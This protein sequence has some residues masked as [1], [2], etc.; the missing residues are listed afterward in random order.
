MWLILSLNSINDD[1]VERLAIIKT[2]NQQPFVSI[3]FVAKLANKIVESTQ[4]CTWFTNNVLD[5]PTKQRKNNF[6]RENIIEYKIV[7]PL[8]K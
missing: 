8:A 2:V 4:R 1:S 6:I 7:V 3:C 5:E